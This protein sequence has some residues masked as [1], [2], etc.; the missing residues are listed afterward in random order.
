MQIMLIKGSRKQMKSVQV[1]ERF[2][3]QS[4]VS[5]TQ[6]AHNNYLLHEWRKKCSIDGKLVESNSLLY[7]F[8]VNI[9]IAI[10]WSLFAVTLTKSLDIF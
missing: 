2:I 3:H 10:N 5:G 8:Y 7:V 6:Q 9:K 1:Y 4:K